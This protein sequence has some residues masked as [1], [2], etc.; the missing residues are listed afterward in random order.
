M[1][2]RP[3]HRYGHVARSKSEHKLSNISFIINFCFVEFFVL[4]VKMHF[5]TATQSEYENGRTE[6]VNIQFQR[7][8]QKFT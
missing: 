3:F 5:K 2:R 7:A 1:Y 6:N 8:I 4:N